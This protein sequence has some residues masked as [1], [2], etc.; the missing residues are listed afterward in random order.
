M[1]S[2]GLSAVETYLGLQKVYFDT[3][4]QE[5]AL[6]WDFFRSGSCVPAM[7]CKGCES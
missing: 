4:E 3:R 5:E 2:G 1:E 6:R 7:A